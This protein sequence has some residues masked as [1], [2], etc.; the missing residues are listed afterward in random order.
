MRNK[1]IYIGKVVEISNSA[2]TIMVDKRIKSAIHI[3]DGESTLL[4]GIGNVIKIQNNIFEITN[5]KVNLDGS[6]FIDYEGI[7]IINGRLLGYIEGGRFVL[8]NSGRLPNILDNAYTLEDKELDC[9]F[10]NASSKSMLTIG[11]YANDYNRFFKID[12]NKF[13]GSH[14]LIVGNTGSGKS[15]TVNS[16]YT[17]LFS[18]VGESIRSKFLIIDTNGEYSHAFSNNKSVKRLSTNSQD[19]NEITI[20]IELVDQEDWKILLEA[21][22]KTQYPIVRTIHRFLRNTIYSKSMR[23]GDALLKYFKETISAICTSSSAAINRF[24][25]ISQLVDD[26]KYYDNNEFYLDLFDCA[27][28]IINK[29]RVNNT[30]IVTL[31]DDFTDASQSLK[32]EVEG[33]FIGENKDEFD[34][35][36]FGFLLNLEHTKRIFKYNLNEKNTAPMIARF[37]S[38]KSDYSKIFTPFGNESSDIINHLFGEKSILVCDVSR[39]NKYIRRIM[40]TFLCSKMYAIKMN[41]KDLISLHLIVDEA[42]NYLSEQKIDKEDAIAKSCIET[43]ETIIK[44]GRK[45][46]VFLTMSTQRPSDISATLLSQA[47]NYVIHKLINPKDI[48]IIKNAVSFID[49]RSISML[50]VLAAGQAIFSGTAFNRPSL[51]NVSVPNSTVVNSSTIDLYSNWKK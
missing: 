17:K 16:V 7:R 13:F 45:F 39:T 4:S 43:F 20:P 22:D 23:I 35:E 51:V 25:I 18:E 47:H 41:N 38:H 27:E 8:G 9:V 36:D 50:S 33:I 30:R 46:G 10:N 40:V 28:A 1:S 2:V 5:E 19:K 34:I 26:L 11:K 49:E 24:Q 14:I 44:E 29:Y 12:I 6:A 48:E 37:N 42:H 31:D 32:E 21:T 3:E 15:T